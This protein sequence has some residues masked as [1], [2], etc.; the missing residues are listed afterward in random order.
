LWALINPPAF[1]KYYHLIISLIWY[2]SLAGAQ[3]GGTRVKA[4][5]W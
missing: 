1:N 3:H 4:S 2:E 5:V